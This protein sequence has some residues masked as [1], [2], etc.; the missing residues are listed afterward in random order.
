MGNTITVL[1]CIET[2]KAGETMK[3][4]SI[5]G[6]TGSIGTQ[7]LDVVRGLPGELKVTAVAAHSNVRLLEEQIREFSPAFAVCFD[8]EAAKALKPPCRTVRCGL[9]RAW[10]GCVK[11][12][13]LPG[14]IWCSTR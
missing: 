10:R 8:E 3:K 11:Q 9:E 2:R 5:L 7:A 12:L 6:S 13:L 4:I 14:Q 1:C